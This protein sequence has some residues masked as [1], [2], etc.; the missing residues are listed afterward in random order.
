MN[1]KEAATFLGCSERAIN[2]YISKRQISVKYEQGKHGAEAM[3]DK[4]ELERFKEARALPAMPY[5]PAVEKN[6]HKR[7]ATAD[8]ADTLATVN[9]SALA[10]I[11]ETVGASIIDQVFSKVQVLRESDHTSVRIS[12][13][14]T[15]TLDQ[16][17]SLSGL[18]KGFLRT[19][20]S[21]RRLKAAKRGRGWNVKRADL[22]NYV[23]KL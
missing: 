20:I 7:L 21:E 5:S 13:R 18:S 16:A 19:A 6:G 11:I 15:L 22:D 10:P 3:F 17:S 2:R 23:K 12:E 4:E 14:L 9:P 1:K 8:R